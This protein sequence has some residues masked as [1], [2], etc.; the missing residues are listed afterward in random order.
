MLHYPVLQRLSH[1]SEFVRKALWRGTTIGFTWQTEKYKISAILIFFYL[2]SSSY[3]SLWHIT[4][5]RN[6][7]FAAL[8]SMF[9]LL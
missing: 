4:N 5:Y 8:P 2:V 9:G 3:T 1:Q 7:I 6:E